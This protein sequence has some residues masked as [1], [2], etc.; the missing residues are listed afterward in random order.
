MNLWNAKDICFNAEECINMDFLSVLFE[1]DRI[2]NQ[3]LNLD[4]QIHQGEMN[5]KTFINCYNQNVNLNSIL[6]N[7]ESALMMIKNILDELDWDN[8]DRTSNYLK[9]LSDLL[10]LRHLLTV[11]EKTKNLILN[12][13]KIFREE[14]SKESNQKFK[15][16]NVLKRNIETLF[17]PE[18]I[19]VYISENL[20]KLRPQTAHGRTNRESKNI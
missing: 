9:N 11:V 6:L 16:T 19:G 15:Y 5:Y 3:K 17:T 14:S 18:E 10:T 1:N 20:N 2:L 12:K 4:L 8:P 7:K 13:I